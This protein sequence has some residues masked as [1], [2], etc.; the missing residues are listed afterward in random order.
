VPE[1]TEG[2]VIIRA[3]LSANDHTETDI[4]AAAEI[5]VGETDCVGGGAA[6]TPGGGY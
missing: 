1:G 5:V 6:A 2:N 4:E 3:R